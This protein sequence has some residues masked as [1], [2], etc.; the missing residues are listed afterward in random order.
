MSKAVRQYY[1]QPC[2]Q[3]NTA[4]LLYNDECGLRLYLSIE[5]SPTTSDRG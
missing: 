2:A 4:L 1:Q 3:F 5:V